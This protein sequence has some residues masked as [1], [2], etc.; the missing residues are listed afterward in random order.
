MTASLSVFRPDP[1]CKR[2][3]RVSG[4]CTGSN[5]DDPGSARGSGRRRCC[6]RRTPFT[7]G[8]ARSGSAAPFRRRRASRSRELSWLM[9]CSDAP[10][11]RMAGIFNRAATARGT[12]W[13][14]SGSRA[15]TTGRSRPNNPHR[16]KFD[17]GQIGRFPQRQTSGF[18]FESERIRAVPRSQEKQRR[19]EIGG[20]RTAKRASSFQSPRS[21]LDARLSVPRATLTLLRHEPAPRMLFC[22]KNACVRGQ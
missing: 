6:D 20:Q 9:V 7:S 2:A 4:V 18:R 16:C 14:Q 5:T 22:W 15:G 21:G 19:I 10:C 17:D 12:S 8:S 13:R 11:N 3:W 1:L